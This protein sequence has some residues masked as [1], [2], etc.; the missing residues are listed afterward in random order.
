[1]AHDGRLG[2]P[3][4]LT[5]TPGT[6]GGHMLEDDSGLTERRLIY[7]K[8]ENVFHIGKESN[9]YEEEGYS[10]EMAEMIANYGT[11]PPERPAVRWP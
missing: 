9:E 11:V 1:M 2:M 4:Y 6:N 7:I 3:P 8:S 10:P 5:S